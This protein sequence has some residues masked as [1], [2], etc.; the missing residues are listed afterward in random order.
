[1]NMKF[2]AG[3]N[4]IKEKYPDTADKARPRPPV[5]ERF[6]K[7]T[8]NPRATARL[9]KLILNTYTL[10][11]TD[12][13]TLQR[14]ANALYESEKRVAIEQGRGGDI[15]KLD[16]VEVL[17]R[18][19]EAILEKEQIQRQ[20]L[21]SWLE[22]LKEA[23][24]EE[25]PMWFKYYVIRSLKDMGR[26]SRDETTYTNRTE[27]TIAP[28]PELNQEALGFVKKALF[29]E[30]AKEGF[31]PEGETDI[32]GFELTE[33]E[34]ATVT[35]KAPPDR[36]EE[37]LKGA[38]RNKRKA[39]FTKAKADF[40]SEQDEAFLAELPLNEAQVPELS[41]ELRRRLATKDFAKLYAFA[42]VECAGNLDRESIEGE[43]VKYDQGSDYRLL[44]NS[45]KGK[46]TGWCTA[47]GSAKNQIENGD[48]YVFYTKNKAGIPTEPR[49]A[50]RMQDDAIAEVRG[51]NPRQELEPELIETA[52]EKYSD[53]PGADKYE[54]ASVDMKQMTSIYN[55][56]FSLNKD[57]KEKT[58]L[59]PTL[60]KQELRFLY[61]LD[62]SIESF[63]YDKDPRIQEVISARG[64]IKADLV[65]ILDCRPEQISTIKDEALSGDI[66]FHYGDLYLGSLQSAEG[67]TLPETLGG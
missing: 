63:G 32:T 6:Q 38:K 30:F 29:H 66:V 15:A 7:I 60:T 43:W 12:E 21:S 44:E 26:F 35:A 50:I 24:E 52:R 8:A 42:Q 47:E 54:K 41:E 3:P 37:A 20:T 55:K 13:A 17:A 23:P 34:I 65:T 11:T 49:I 4:F 40:A 57:T 36:L 67:L 64:D 25:Y 5:E 28:F 1:M 59:S 48:F 62:D 16:E 51:V 31:S 56:C 33:E 19:R 10:D 53:L 9:E 61:E 14:L 27:D 39:Y 58:Y 45:L 22:Y 2:E 18:Y 46:G